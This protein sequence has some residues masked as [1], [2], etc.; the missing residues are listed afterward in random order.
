[1]KQTACALRL[2]LNLQDLPNVVTTSLRVT[3][4]DP[5]FCDA[6]CILSTANICTPTLWS[7]VHQTAKYPAPERSATS[8]HPL[9]RQTLLA[10][11]KTVHAAGSAGGVKI[12]RRR[13]ASPLAAARRLSHVLQVGALSAAQGRPR[14]PVPAPAR[15]LEEASREVGLGWAGGRRRCTILQWAYLQST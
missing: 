8:S 10:R 9:Q 14:T 7:T 2:F 15:H 4:K 13:L 12:V 6:M 3:P 5:P 1:M 11:Q